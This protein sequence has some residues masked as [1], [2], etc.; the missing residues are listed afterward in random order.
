MYFGR[1]ALIAVFGATSLATAGS[2]SAACTGNNNA[3]VCYEIHPENAPSVDPAGSTY[4]DCIYI[5]SPTCLPV[6][7]PIPSVSPPS[8]PIVEVSC[9]IN[10]RFQC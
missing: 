7:I 8:G 10:V 6:S 4:E 9:E 2:V 5:N 1:L 3:R